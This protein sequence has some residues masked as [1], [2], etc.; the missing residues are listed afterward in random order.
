MGPGLIKISVALLFVL[1]AYVQVIKRTVTRLQVAQAPKSEFGIVPV[2]GFG[3]H[4][5]GGGVEY[6]PDPPL[7]QRHA[8][9]LRYCS[10]IFVHGLGSNPDTTWTAKAQH[11][12]SAANENEARVFWIR[13]F[14]PQD[15]PHSI[16]ENTRVFLY[17]HDSYWQRDAVQTRLWS[18]GEGL[19]H[20]IR[21]SVRNSEEV[22]LV[23]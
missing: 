9:A 12:E 11:P 8:N 4:G 16:R 23:S 17:N 1:I 6:G 21:T 22:G 18:L 7:C 3:S 14:L 20:R 19:L 2:N 13:D 5:H 15:L 10:I